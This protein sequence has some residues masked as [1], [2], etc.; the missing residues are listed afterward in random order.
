MSVTAHK[1]NNTNSYNIID[2]LPPKVALDHIRADQSLPSL[3]LLFINVVPRMSNACG[4]LSVQWLILPMSPTH[5]PAL[6]VQC[7]TPHS[8]I[9]H[10]RIEVPEVCGRWPIAISLTSWSPVVRI[11]QTG[12]D[13]LRQLTSIGPISRPCVLVPTTSCKPKGARSGHTCTACA[14]RTEQSI[15][16]RQH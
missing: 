6:P 16:P 11:Y 12:Q 3:P 10:P 8:Y 14:A 5:R 2:E 4:H 15:L 13:R 9:V 1:I 7:A